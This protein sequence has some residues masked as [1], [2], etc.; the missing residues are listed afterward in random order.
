MSKKA[1]S[2]SLNSTESIPTGELGLLI[3]K[4]RASKGWTQV[5]LSMEVFGH[6]RNGRIIS[7]Y[8]LGQ[9]RPQVRTLKRFVEVLGDQLVDNLRSYA[10]DELKSYRPAYG[11]RA[12]DQQ[13]RD[14][15]ESASFSEIVRQRLREKAITQRDFAVKMGV[16]RMTVSRWLSDYAFPTPKNLSMIAEF[17]ELDLQELRDPGYRRITE[18]PKRVF[19]QPAKDEVRTVRLRETAAS[20]PDQNPLVRFGVS[21]NAKLNLT[22]TLANENDYET[23]EALRSELLSAKGPIERLMER[24]GKNP[25]VPQADMFGPLISEYAKE[26]SKDPN[27]IN[28]TTLYARGARFYNARRRASQ[29][30]ASGEWPELDA[31]EN[32]AIDAICDLHGPMIMASGAGRKLVESAHQYEVPPDLYEKD[33]ETSEEF[34]ELI[35]A[36]TE[37]VEAETADVYR[38]LTAKIEGDPQ[39]KRSR[40]LGIAATGSAL[41]VIVGGSAW[42]GAGGTVA[43]LIVPAVAIG[44]TGFVGGFFWEAVKTMPSF[45]KATGVVGDNF[46][47]VIDKAE[48]HADDKE[49]A[50]LKRMADLVDRNRPLFERV[51]NLRPEFGWAKKYLRTG[52]ILKRVHIIDD[53]LKF[54]EYLSKELSRQGIA[55]SSSNRTDGALEF[56]S[57]NY[58]STH[59]IILDLSILAA[60]S[61]RSNDDASII[62]ALEQLFDSINHIDSRLLERTIIVTGA[63]SVSYPK[64]AF[65]AG[66]TTCIEKNNR[67]FI[68]EIMSA[69]EK[70]DFPYRM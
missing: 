68:T 59:A 16:S 21:E 22:P 52:P 13:S 35:A 47:R 2:D 11:D 7:Q 1:S 37:L 39:L 25:N 14:Q 61:A 29:Q 62:S 51:S 27:S 64:V 8:E 23:I 54:T 46:E 69:I 20:I 57:T 31:D 26:L 30:I 9:R 48:K 58:D 15:L 34:G 10:V 56:L 36:Q 12:I 70:V 60:S 50:L 67:S 6:E 32:E 17:L 44:A 65:D 40:G 53:S 45:K 63:S 38:E 19:E 41:T 33:Q 43:T 42:F 28:Y 4:A 66:V 49:R 24:Y 18:G 55:V 5:Q 3:R